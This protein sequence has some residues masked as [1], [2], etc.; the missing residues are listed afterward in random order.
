MPTARLLIVGSIKFAAFALV[1]LS[2]KMVQEHKLAS[3]G[4]CRIRWCKTP[5]LA[6]SV[7][8]IFDA[9]KIPFQMAVERYRD[10]DRSR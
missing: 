3:M 4:L 8:L 5:D 9:P 6:C 7:C 10:L 2:Q 1:V